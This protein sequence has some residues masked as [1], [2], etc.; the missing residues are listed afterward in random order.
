MSVTK[1]K[2]W[3]SP[4]TPRC[5]KE[6][7]AGI[8]GLP[9]MDRIGTYL[10]TLIFTPVTLLTPINIWWI[11][12][13]RE[14]KDVKPNIFRWLAGPPSSKL[15]SPLSRP[16]QCK[17]CF[18]LKKFV[19][20]STNWAVISSGGILIITGVVT[21]LTGLRSLF[22]RKLVGW[23]YPSLA[24]E[25]MLSWWIRPDAFIP[26]P[27]LYGPRCSKLNIFL[28]L[29]CLPV[30][31]P[32]EDHIFGPFSHWGSNC[33]VEVWVGL[34]KMVKLFRFGRIHGFLTAHCIVISRVL[35][36]P[37][38]KTIGLTCCGQTTHGLSN[39]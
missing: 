15:L 9:T 29:P 4:R 30:L 20:T 25:T 11:I 28:I 35:S 38:M 23:E 18:S 37:M 12:F 21:Q 36:S 22:P 5:T 17:P 1:S 32:H 33:F 16:M 2:V 39:L 26:I 34:S 13:V 3:F 7:L 31:E 8:L 19:I 10:G 24:I 6:Q 27:R 14:L